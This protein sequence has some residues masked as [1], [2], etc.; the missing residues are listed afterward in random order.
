MPPRLKPAMR[1]TQLT[2][3]PYEFVYQPLHLRIH[4]RIKTFKIKKYKHRPNINQDFFKLS[5]KLYVI[6]EHI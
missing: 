3:P 6:S 4:N 2:P 5:L 1:P